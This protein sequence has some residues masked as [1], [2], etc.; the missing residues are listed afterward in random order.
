MESLGA[1]VEKQKKS[2]KSGKKEKAAQPV[3][4]C[5]AYGY[6]EIRCRVPPCSYQ[7]AP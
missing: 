3:S 5:A 6:P 4:D 7:E 2:N 1:G